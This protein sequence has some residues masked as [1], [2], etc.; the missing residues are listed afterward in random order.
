MN[1]LVIIHGWSD[2]AQSFVK[3]ADWIKSQINVRPL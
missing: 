2:E 1:P 3:L